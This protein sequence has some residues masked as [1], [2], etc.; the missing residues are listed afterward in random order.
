MHGRV[1]HC[2]HSP[3]ITRT[4]KVPESGQFSSHHFHCWSSDTEQVRKYD[5][6][7]SVAA[8]V[9]QLR[10]RCVKWCVWVAASSDQTASVRQR[11][12][13]ESE[14]KSGA[15]PRVVSVMGLR[16]DVKKSAAFPPDLLTGS[17]LSF[18]PK[19]LWVAPP[20][21]RLARCLRVQ[22]YDV[23]ASPISYL[24]KTWAADF[25]KPRES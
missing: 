13:H 18:V 19:F 5:D 25:F 17:S 15:S 20:K 23:G 22:R 24:W 21:Q 14:A 3:S 10:L 7:C 11:R 1:L 9:A 8:T 16:R 2:R 6:K 4:P 12:W